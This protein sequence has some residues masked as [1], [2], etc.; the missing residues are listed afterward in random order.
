MKLNT[1]TINGLTVI[2][3]DEPRIDAGAAIRFKDAMRAAAD[4]AGETLILD[5]ARVSFVDSSG[6]GAVVAA[7]KGL[8]PQRRLHLAGLSGDVEK[9]FRL[10]RMDQ[11]FEIFASVDEAVRQRAAG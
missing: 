6:L 1:Q 11:V 5:L 9:V 4:T 10:T 7:M 8:G 3:V 2:A